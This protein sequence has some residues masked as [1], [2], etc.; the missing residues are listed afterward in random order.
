M[1]D[2]PDKVDINTIMPVLRELSDGLGDLNRRMDTIVDFLELK[3][4]VR[5]VEDEARDLQQR[6]EVLEGKKGK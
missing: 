1:S 6:L 3:D 5:R 2:I 4:R